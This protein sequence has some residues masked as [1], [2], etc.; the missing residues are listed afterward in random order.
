[1]INVALMGHGVV[2]SGVAEILLYHRD[3][4]TEKIKEEIR[5]K[6]ILDL[7]DFDG[8]A[9][10]P[11]FTKRF[12]D[13]LDDPEIRI[14]VEVMGGVTFAYDYTKACLLAGKSVV[15]SNKELVAA[16]GQELL[17]IAAANNVNFLFEASVGG[18]I[19]ILR[20]MAQCLAANTITEVLGILNGT[21]NFILTKMV[22]ENMSFA[23]ALRLAQQNGY[24]EKDPTADVEGHD[25]C[26]KLCILAALAFGQHVYPA[27]VETTGITGI[28]R[29]DVDY[30][31][32][33]NAVVKLI[34]RARRLPDG[35]VTA[36]VYPALISRAHILANV[37]DVFNAILVHG[38]CVGDVLF[39][40]R[41]A[42]KMPTASAVVAD[43]LDCAKHLTARK[44]LY[45]AEGA[46]D[47]VVPATISETR[48]YVRASCDDPT[49]A[50][51]AAS[52]AFGEELFTIRDNAAREIA[53]LTPT[54]T[55]GV[56]RETLAALPC[57]RDPVVYHVID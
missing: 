39:Y 41:G 4:L 43:V 18:G 16:K 19:P 26:R 57:L 31:D 10:A 36:A 53:F 23:D 3:V 52:D 27:Q 46:P 55:E 20:P 51:K 48:L 33:F 7:R 56:L 13:I 2:G 38:D 12:A 8:L 21:T 15:T 34:G 42:G 25:A 1:M 28:S 24:A 45:W 9:Y 17:E 14:V 11:L 29:T 35:H 22:A 49:A 37:N 40:G 54:G 5:L 47:F 6:Y 50:A 30:A 44:Y 32:R